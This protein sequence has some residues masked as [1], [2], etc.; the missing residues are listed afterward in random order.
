MCG[1]NAINF[2]KA[3]IKVIN[4]SANGDVIVRVA[5]LEAG[6]YQKYHYVVLDSDELSTG[7]EGK[8]EVK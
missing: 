2:Q 4:A 1:Y 6:F 3:G 7:K 5:L 8:K